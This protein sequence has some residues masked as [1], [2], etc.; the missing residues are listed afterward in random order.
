VRSL[1]RA[2]RQARVVQEEYELE[3]GATSLEAPAKL[4]G[5]ASTRSVA[6]IAGAVTVALIGIAIR[7]WAFSPFS[8]LPSDFNGPVAFRA[9]YLATHH[10]FLLHNV[11]VPTYWSGGVNTRLGFYLYEAIEAAVYLIARATAIPE[12]MIHQV[13]LEAALCGLVCAVVLWQSRSRGL[14]VEVVCVS[15]IATLGTPIAINYMTGW[16]IA[17]AY[18]LLLVATWVFLA[19]MRPQLRVGTL[20]LLIVVAPALYHTFSFAFTIYCLLLWVLSTLSRSERALPS[21]IAILVIYLCYEVYVGTQFF[22]NIIK[23]TVNI[24]TLQFLHNK[25]VDVAIASVSEGSIN[26]RY[27]HL[28]IYGALATSVALVAFL[29]V[30]D[31]YY[32]RKIG[33]PLPKERHTFGIAITAMGFS[34]LVLSVAFGFQ[35]SLEF[36][37]NRGASYLNVPAALSIL[38]WLRYYRSLRVWVILCVVAITTLSGA[39]FVLESRTVYAT[40]KI[41]NS[42]ASGFNWLA[43]RL[44][45]RDVVFTDFRLSGPFIASGHLSVIGVGSGELNTVHLLHEIYYGHNAAKAVHGIESLRTYGDHRSADYIFL[46]YGITRNYPGLTNYGGHFPPAPRSFFKMLASAPGWKVVYDRHGTLVYKRIA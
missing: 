33:R 29:T 14:V 31:I 9:R 6:W 41:T 27:V 11:H 12:S 26:L 5:P 34:V 1:S 43:H 39:A 37:I 35:F 38:Y 20:L 23:S 45:Q 25:A 30:R 42:E 40:N 2:N 19:D 4:P 18:V 32:F 17:Y 7:V 21:P 15:A 44:H 46:S 22:G 36:L 3:A 13:V 28:L 24:L 8:E 16:N 10:W